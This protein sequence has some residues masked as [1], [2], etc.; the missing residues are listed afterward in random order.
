MH[1]HFALGSQTAMPLQPLNLPGIDTR[2]IKHDNTI[3]KFRFVYQ[4]PP[5]GN[6]GHGEGGLHVD[7]SN[8]DIQ[9]QIDR[10]L[11][12]TLHRVRSGEPMRK[13]Q[14]DHFLVD[15]V[16][17]P[18]KAGTLL[19]FEQHRRRI[20]T[21]ADMLVLTLK[22]KAK[23]A[24]GPGDRVHIE[25]VCIETSSKGRV[26]DRVY[27]EA[28]SKGRTASCAEHE[29]PRRT[30]L[31]DAMGG[32]ASSTGVKETKEMTNRQRIHASSARE[33]PHMVTRAD[34]VCGQSKQP[35]ATVVRPTEKRQSP[36]RA[37]HGVTSRSGL[38]EK[39]LPVSAAQP[40]FSGHPTTTDT[41]HQRHHQRDDEM[42]DIVYRRTIVHSR[43]CDCDGCQSR[44]GAPEPEATQQGVTRAACRLPLQSRGVA[45]EREAT[46]QGVARAACRLPLQSRG[47]APEHEATEQGMAR[48]ACRLPLQSR[49]GAPEHEATE[50]GM[51]REECR[52]PLQSRAV[53]LRRDIQ[54][55]ELR[56]E[57]KLQRFAVNSP[58]G[59][60]EL[61]SAKAQTLKRSVY[62]AFDVIMTPVKKIFRSALELYETPQ[63]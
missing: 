3:Y 37:D 57:M 45:P 46:E 21:C 38:G 27:A 1:F 61:S 29:S 28:S 50:Q 32:C 9:K 22:A 19:V 24:V 36:E 47:G 55:E 2:L 25:A 7:F 23:K 41:L 49:G 51:A 31:R 56:E 15:C 16:R 13:V 12:V 40:S 18:W 43:H 30:V 53:R 48:A 20:E 34:P 63:E 35:V 4:A 17:T 14:T 58:T 42:P 52:P 26:R 44:G 60:A 5:S 8:P 39:S 10:I 59:S 33:V 11:Q 62:N 54:Q 6:G